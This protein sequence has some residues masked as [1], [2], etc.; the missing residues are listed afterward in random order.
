MIEMRWKV[1]TW[2][3]YGDGMVTEKRAEPVLQFRRVLN[4]DE[5]TICD[6]NWS[7]WQDVETEYVET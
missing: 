2:T 7:E 4:P 1:E 6:P 5:L 3:C